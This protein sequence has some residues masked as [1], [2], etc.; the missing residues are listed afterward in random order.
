MPAELTH[1]RAYLGENRRLIIGRSLVAAA[2]G[3]LPIPLVEDWL[4]SRIQR[5]TIRKIAESRSVD[6]DEQA[7][8]ALADGSERPP[9]WAEIAGGTVLYR[10]LARQWRRLLVVYLVARRAQAAARAF[11]V[12]S[13]F[14]HYCARLHVGMGLDGK[15]GVEVRALID[16]AIAETPGGLG[17]RIFRRGALGLARAGVKA[18]LKLADA[19]TGG[20]VRRLL[21][22]NQEVDAIQVVDEAI[23]EQLE[24][25][26]SFLSRTA[27][28]LELQL[29]AEANPYVDRLLD[30]FDRLWR[31]Q[32][33]R[34]TAAR[35]EQPAREP[36]DRPPGTEP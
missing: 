11:L 6:A 35:G 32:E 30:T 8:T 36:D 29:A 27:A 14:D 31:E 4:A 5:G 15:R 2:A 16:Q 1:N 34:R 12:G 24:A 25:K 33:S 26:K 3:A 28:A 9:D 22:K 19:V 20:M 18:P 10:L 13:L 7:I 21:S 23:E 17:R